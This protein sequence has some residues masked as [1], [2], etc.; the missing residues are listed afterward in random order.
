MAT[1][2]LAAPCSLAEYG[3]SN[4]T[5]QQKVDSHAS[6]SKRLCIVKYSVTMLMNRLPFKK[7]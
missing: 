5:Q 3:I 2:E 1:N 7:L 4:D 6:H